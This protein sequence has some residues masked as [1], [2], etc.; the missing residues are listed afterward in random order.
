[1]A[2]KVPSLLLLSDEQMKILNDVVEAGKN[3]F[4]TGPGGTGKSFLLKTI[5]EELV[6]ANKK[7]QVCALTGRAAVLLDCGA[8]TIHSWGGVG[9]ATGSYEKI[10]D[11][12]VKRYF[13]LA[14]MLS[15][16]FSSG[17]GGNANVD[18]RTVNVLIIDE[19]SMMSRKL[20]EVLDQIARIIRRRPLEPFGGIQV[21]FFGDFFQLL[22]V[23]ESMSGSKRGGSNDDVSV[24]DL[25]MSHDL[26]FES[27]VWSRLF[28][29]SNHI[30]LTHVFRQKDEDFVKILN[31]VRRGRLTKSSD[32]KLRARVGLDPF[33]SNKDGDQQVCPRLFPLR[34]DADALNALKFE[35]LDA[36]LEVLSYNIQHLY[37]LEVSHLDS[38]LSETNI[39]ETEDEKMQKRVFAASCGKPVVADIFMKKTKSVVVAVEKTMTLEEMDK[40]INF[41]AKNSSCEDVLFLKMG[42]HVMLTTN[43]DIEANLCNGSLGVVTGFSRCAASTASAVPGISTSSMKNKLYPVV[44]FHATEETRQ[45]VPRV[46]QSTAHPNLGFSQIP[47]RL[48]W[49]LTIHCAQGAT[50]DRAIVDV[51]SNVFAVGQTY[52]AISR[53]RSL[54]NLYLLSYDS[55]KIR[56]SQKVLDFDASF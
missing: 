34:R 8:R 46:Y 43:L 36:D 16:I 10:V 31:Q 2:V 9:L 24:H 30:R 14:K 40:E 29:K 47:L 11:R 4:I 5:Y 41:Y 37:D 52:V 56:V 23:G 25:Q 19:I 50:L 54:E 3:V 55:S 33:L 44:Y 45:I 48:A 12:T 35:E 28:S 51:G 26:C 1:V 53:V 42:A 27:P 6:S 32:A 7:V 15:K 39:A 38:I 17:G 13:Y 21:V 18:W 20:L 22:P 49:G